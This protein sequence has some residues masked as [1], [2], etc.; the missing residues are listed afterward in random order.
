MNRI[1]RYRML[2][3]RRIVSVLMQM[4]CMAIIVWQLCTFMY[5]RGYNTGYES[6]FQD[7]TYLERSDDG[8]KYGVTLDGNGNISQIIRIE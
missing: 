6:A 2:K 3:M 1:R 5:N 8:M 7:V 4:I